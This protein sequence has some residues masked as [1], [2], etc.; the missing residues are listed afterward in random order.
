M[1]QSQ[2]NDIDVKLSFQGNIKRIP[3]V[4]T[5]NE[6]CAQATAF[7]K[8]SGVKE[9]QPSTLSI[10][11]V[12][13]DN[14]TIHIADDSDLQIAYVVALQTE[15][16]IKFIVKLPA[17]A[18]SASTEK[19]SSDAKKLMNT[20]SQPFDLSQSIANLSAA[21]NPQ[22]F[23][24]SE[25]FPSIDEPQAVVPSLELPK[26]EAQPQAQVEVEC[27]LEDPECTTKK[28]K[29][30]K[31]KKGKKCG[32]QAA[33]V[34]RKAIKSLIKAEL[35]KVVPG[36]FDQMMQE[37][38]ESEPKIQNSG[39]VHERVECDGCHICPIV[40]DRYKCAV[41]KDFDY[42]A[43]CEENMGHEHPFLKIKKA[44]D[45]PIMMLTVLKDQ[46]EEALGKEESKE[47][48]GHRHEHKKFWKEMMGGF[49]Q[50]LGEHKQKEG[51]CNPWAFADGEKRCGFGK[52]MYKLK[53]AVLVNKPE[54]LEALPGSV[55]I[56]EIEVKN[57]THWGWKQ[58][59]FLGMDE[60]QNIEGMPIEVVHLPIDQELKS[61]E[62]LKMSVPIT[63]CADAFPSDEPFQCTL[64]FRGPKGNEFGQPIPISIKI[65]SKLSEPAQKEAEHTKPMSQIE[66]VKLAVKLFD[67]MK[68]ERSNFD[69]CLA[70]VTKFNGD[71]ERAQKF[72]ELQEKE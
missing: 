58:G 3:N 18:E 72:L 35:E 19:Q 5:W 29:G 40:G 33:D 46:I 51:G 11:Y 68:L 69:K 64:R 1:N 37:P 34:P 55:A 59:V 44:G 60:D 38:E 26:E 41:C 61:F 36:L 8:N 57:C 2:I 9:F 17:A 49:L 53:R 63:V 16:K 65:V 23:K 62:V 30:K 45:A 21:V 43:K 32:G 31:G 56:A 47:Q 52:G 28:C 13:S 48:K 20:E 50:K 54:T 12:D 39:V 25:P 22:S 4:Q 42:C 15:R 14:D 67:S 10:T 6:L 24:A 7:V 66:L 71:V 27:D 70:I